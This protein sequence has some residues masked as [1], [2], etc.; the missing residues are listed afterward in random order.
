[1]DDTN[2]I[3][4]TTKKP[5]I[6]PDHNRTKVGVDTVDKLCSSHSVSRITRR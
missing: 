2:E 4:E 1:M 5:Q 6:I 3:Y